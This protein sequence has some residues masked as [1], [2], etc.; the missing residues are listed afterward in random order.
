MGLSVTSGVGEKTGMVSLRRHSIGESIRVP[1]AA[2]RTILL[3]EDHRLTRGLLARSLE[4]EG[5]RVV[6]V[7]SSRQA[8]REFDAIDPDALVV[9]IELGDRPNGIELAAILCAQAPYLGVVF[10]SNY[11]LLDVVEGSLTPPTRS[12]FLQKDAVDDS[13]QITDAIEAALDDRATGIPVPH[14]PEN[15]PLR[16]LSSTQMA[17][18]RLIAEGWNNAEIAERRGITLRSAERIVSRTFVALGVTDDDTVSPRVAATRIYTRVFGVP[19]AT[20]VRQ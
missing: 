14:L 4:A 18:L 10:L 5:F 13:R 11:P 8:I 19:E 1:A 17:V 16:A 15:H 12:V 6:A 2:P 7:E 3:V 20:R 9:D